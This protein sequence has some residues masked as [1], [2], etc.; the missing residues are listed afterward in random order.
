MKL[1]F[2]VV[3]S[4]LAAGC[5]SLTPK[6]YSFVNEDSKTAEIAFKHGN[7]GVEFMYFDQKSLPEPEKGEYWSPISFP[8]GIPLSIMVHTKYSQEAVSGGGGFLASLVTMV[9]TAAVSANRAVDTDV[10]FECPPLE[11]GKSY[12][13]EFRKSAG[14]K[15]K[16]A[17]IL[18]DSN[19]KA[20]IHIQ[21]FEF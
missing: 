2:L 12:L 9:A 13:L 11:S 20:I 14:L 17:L 16:N 8:A 7:P 18:K 6:P 21:E 10:L 1:F 3:V 15:G 19:S 4:V 5:A